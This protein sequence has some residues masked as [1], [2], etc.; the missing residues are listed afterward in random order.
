MTPT[1]E[2]LARHVRMYDEYAAWWL[3]Q[4]DKTTS[5]EFWLEARIEALEHD[6][7]LMRTDRDAAEYHV[8]ALEK[9][10]GLLWAFDIAP[11]FDAR[12]KYTE[13]KAVEWKQLLERAHA[14]A[15][16]PVA[17]AEDEPE[18][19]LPWDEYVKKVRAAKKDAP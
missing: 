1:P 10:Y 19:L 17:L 9:A 18:R 12:G 2:T 6:L 3:A 15:P 8:E 13:R 5:M 16:R 7:V 4:E 11:T 14:I